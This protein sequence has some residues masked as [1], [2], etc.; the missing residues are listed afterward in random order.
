MWQGRAPRVIAS[1]GSASLIVALRS[2]GVFCQHAA[3]ALTIHLLAIGQMRENLGD[4]PA[5]RRRLPLGKTQ[6][7]VSRHRVQQKRRLSQERHGGRNVAS[8]SGLHET[9]P[10]A[11]CWKDIVSAYRG[12]RE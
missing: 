10:T 8:R 7:H 1:G 11:G 3:H 6:G 12:I 5:V 2:R 9:P 4:G